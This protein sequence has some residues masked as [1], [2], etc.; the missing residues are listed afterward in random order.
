MFISVDLY[1]YQAYYTFENQSS[2][3]L[4]LFYLIT[5]FIST[6]ITT[7][8]FT[9]HCCEEDLAKGKMFS[10]VPWLHI[11]LIINQ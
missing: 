4:A 5:L 3:H 9:V 11:N 7:D 2:C 8:S 10:E 6:R 1:I